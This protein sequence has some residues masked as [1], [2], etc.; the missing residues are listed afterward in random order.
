MTVQ[1]PMSILFKE[2]S[3]TLGSGI[4]GLFE[5][6]LEFFSGEPLIDW[7]TNQSHT[8]LMTINNVLDRIAWVRRQINKGEKDE[9]F[10]DIFLS[11][12]YTLSGKSKPNILDETTKLK[13]ELN[14]F[15][16]NPKVPRYIKL[17]SKFDLSSVKDTIKAIDVIIDRKLTI[18]D[19][20]GKQI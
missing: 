15:Y 18:R 19:A 5:N 12:L 4:E 16:K 11:S 17:L 9:P 8:N 2:L 7:L 13:N 10:K 14:A 1:T 20:E 3:R 6:T